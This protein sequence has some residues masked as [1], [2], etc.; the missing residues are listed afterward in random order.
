MDRSKLVIEADEL[1]SK[2][3]DENLR[4]FDTTILFFGSTSG[5]TAREMYVQAHIP[6]AAFLD[7]QKLTDSESDYMLMV[8]PEVQLLEQIGALGISED[9]Q[10]VLYAPGVL[11][12]ATRA[13][14]ILHYAGHPN[15][16]IL[17]GGLEAWKKAGGELEQ[18]DNQY[19]PASYNG[20]FNPR[21]FASKE[22]VLDAM[23]DPRVGIEN[24]LLKESYT[25]AHI[26][27]SY[28]LP[29]TDLMHEMNAFVD[30]HELVEKLKTESRFKRIITYC[31]GGIAATVNAVA[32]LLIGKEDVAVYDGSLYEWVSED[33][34]MTETGDGNWAIWG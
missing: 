33:L 18:G 16:R 4:L 3:S 9:S 21:L 14:W 26:T 5:L 12:A 2:I 6:G 11:P 25:A 32:H 23:E 30:Q 31:G 29:C 20:V 28:C 13:W 27:G 19:A 1:L 8:A 22:E 7:H 17:N 10:V 34:P 24:A 15:V